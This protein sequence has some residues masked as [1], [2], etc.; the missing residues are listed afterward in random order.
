[1][2]RGRESIQFI[3]Q[4]ILPGL[5]S[6]VNVEEILQWKIIFSILSRLKIAV[7]R[8]NHSGHIALQTVLWTDKRTA[9]FKFNY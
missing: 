4:P 9:L 2:E 1:M 5:Y 7:A 6:Q 8:G 3:D